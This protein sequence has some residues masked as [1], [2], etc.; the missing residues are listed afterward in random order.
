MDNLKFLP[1]LRVS[2][3]SYV[4]TDQTDRARQIVTRILELDP[5]HRISAARIVRNL[6]KAEDLAKMVED[7][8]LAGLPE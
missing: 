6:R 2:A 8:R 7:L 5:G 1:S 4:A 3:A